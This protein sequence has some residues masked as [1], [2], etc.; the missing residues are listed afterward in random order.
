M[1]CCVFGCLDDRI[2]LCDPSSMEIARR[3]KKNG[4]KSCEKNAKKNKNNPDDNA[5]V[6]PSLTKG[7]H[8]PHVTAKS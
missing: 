7:F 3:A 5:M 8:A 1:A 6:S 4:H 2:A